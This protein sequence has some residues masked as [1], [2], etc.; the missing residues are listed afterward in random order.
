[1]QSV[2]KNLKHGLAVRV[3]VR[4]RMPPADK[5]EEFSSAIE[6]QILAAT[7]AVVEDGT[8]VN[9]IEFELAELGSLEHP[10]S[11]FTRDA[12]ERITGAKNPHFFIHRAE[13]NLGGVILVV[14]DS[15]Q[16]D[17]M[18]HEM[19][20]TFAE[21]AGRQL[22]GSRAGALMATFEGL[23]S[24]ALLNIAANEGDGGIYS[25]L[26]WEAST[27]LERSDYPHVVGVGFL[28]EPDF[29]TTDGSKGGI[30]YWIPRPTSPLWNPVFSGLFGKV[31]RQP[32][33]V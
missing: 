33:V 30:T 32:L 17:S 21:S 4:E 27:F 12:V 14:I 6:Q 9:L 31:H 29:S 28:S 8:H 10:V 20:T 16:P 11:Q 15:A 13:V 24:D 18:L 2:A 7:S 19:F 3:T 25:S 23:G 22:T 1:M 5:L 26:A